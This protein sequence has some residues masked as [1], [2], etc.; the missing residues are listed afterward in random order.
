MQLACGLA[1]R[2]DL[3]VMITNRRRILQ[4]AFD[5]EQIDDVSQYMMLRVPELAPQ[6]HNN[7]ERMT[8]QK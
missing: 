3:A 7:S 8:I 2:D 1:Q 6:F 4:F 5:M